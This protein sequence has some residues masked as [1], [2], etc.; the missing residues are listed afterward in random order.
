M[1]SKVCDPSATIKQKMPT[2]VGHQSLDRIVRSKQQ[3]KTGLAWCISVHSGER[4]EVIVQYIP[5]TRDGALLETLTNV[6]R[7]IFILYF[8]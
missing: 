6:N 7:G 5:D 2:I 4:F 8:E 3:N 1:K